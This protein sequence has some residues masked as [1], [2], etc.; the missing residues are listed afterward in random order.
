MSN[1]QLL[2]ITFFYLCFF[3]FAH[4]VLSS[5]FVP[6]CIS[7]FANQNNFHTHC[8]HDKLVEPWLIALSILETFIA[9]LYMYGLWSS[10][11]YFDLQSVKS[12]HYIIQ[13]GTIL[14]VLRI[15]VV[16]FDVSVLAQVN[17]LCL[18]IIHG[19]LY[20]SLISGIIDISLFMMTTCAIQY[21]FREDDVLFPTS[22]QT[23]TLKTRLASMPRNS[24]DSSQNEFEHT[25][26]EYDEL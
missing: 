6:E 17:A 2:C 13:I 15:A 19:A 9:I 23:H 20:L 25:D 5:V 24:E 11:S 21:Y 22:M 8:H 16:L 1:H 12:R 26:Q 14:L 18:E 10:R 7:L 4:V 3:A